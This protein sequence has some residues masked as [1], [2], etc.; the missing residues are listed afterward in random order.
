[1]DFVW[2]GVGLNDN[3]EAQVDPSYQA[4]RTSIRPLEFASKDLGIGGH[5]RMAVTFSTTTAGPVAGAP[6]FAMRWADP[7]MFYTLLNVQASAIIT[8][9]FS[10]ATAL[11]FDLILA[12]S[13][14]T[15]PSGGTPILLADSAQKMRSNQM[16]GSLL[17]SSGAMQISAGA[18]ITLGTCVLD[19]QPIGYGALMASTTTVGAAG[20][21]ITL[22]DTRDLQ[23]HP[24]VLK[25]NEGFAIR[26]LTAFPATGVAK[27]GFVFSWAE[28][29]TY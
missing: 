23:C 15:N 27:I 16:S 17:G 13:Y 6:L 5:F 3:I 21:P 10:A 9:V 12:R 20:P 1:M 2:K 8:T 18:G 26:N 7:R 29:P 4:G 24:P 22:F 25:A 11:D 14:T 28:L 19:T